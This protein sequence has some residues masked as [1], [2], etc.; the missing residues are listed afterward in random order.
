MRSKILLVLTVFTISACGSKDATSDLGQASSMPSCNLDSPV[1]IPNNPMDKGLLFDSL[2]LEGD[3]NDVHHKE[4]DGST[5]RLY[6]S[7]FP[8]YEGHLK[9]SY[10][11]ASISAE[12]QNIGYLGLA[13]RYDGN[14]NFS[15][16]S[17]QNGDSTIFETASKDFR[18]SETTVKVLLKQGKILAVS[19]SYPIENPDKTSSTKI[20]THSLCVKSMKLSDKL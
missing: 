11:G 12:D 13:N 14:F 19:L 8:I 20:V 9:T 17:H 15:G 10:M 16:G 7:V 18:N 1:A 6:L 3:T 5:G 2:V 4:S